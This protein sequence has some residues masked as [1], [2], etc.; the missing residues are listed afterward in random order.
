M[1]VSASGERAAGER[2]QRG[3]VPDFFVVGH[4][5]SGTTALHEMLDDH[6]Q[7]FMPNPKEPRFLASDMESRFEPPR[8]RGRQLPKTLEEYL[9]LFASAGP[10]QLAGEA[11]PSYLFSHV[12]ARAI[13]ELQPAARIIA[14]LR[15]PASFL[16]S[17]H[18]ELLRSHVETE[19]DLGKAIALERERSEGRR[20]PR[21]SHRPQLLRYSEHVRYVEQLRRYHEVFPR[22]QVLVL[23]YEEFRDDNER[24]LRQVLRFLGVDDSHP[25]AI[26]QVHPTV[27][28]IRS[29]GLD[30]LLQNV[31]QGSTRGSR[32]AKLA[33]KAIAPR[34][35][36][37]GA[38]RV[39]MRRGVYG[40][41]PPPDERLT[42]ALRERFK[43]E[44]V[45]LGEY[46]DRDLV[47]MWGY[48]DV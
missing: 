29:Q 34:R 14:I 36:R 38:F 2:A 10:G 23:I 33:V 26:R 11:S 31:T 7:I 6:P 27:R 24:T 20:V 40:D 9:A 22:E 44:V 46:L 4:H 32:A 19:R 1:S 8:T 28:G 13:A 45:A 43:P 30:D 16:R 48:E 47:A 12:A 3:R 5:K 17:L 21:R 15:E 18:L 35:M 37:R 39:A 42:R 41:V 25:I